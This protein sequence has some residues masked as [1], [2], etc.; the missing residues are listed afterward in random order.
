M[1]K[2][3]VC[4]AGLSVR[5]RI[6]GVEHPMKRSRIWKKVWPHRHPNCK[7]TLENN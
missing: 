3:P 6:P 7:W 4:G 5:Y 1:K 2:C